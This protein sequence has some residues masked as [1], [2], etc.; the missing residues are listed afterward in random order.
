MTK[1]ESEDTLENLETVRITVIT[2]G[3]L[4]FSS[5]NVSED[6]HEAW[7]GRALVFPQL[8][9]ELGLAHTPP[10]SGHGAL[11]VPPLPQALP[12]PS[13]QGFRNSSEELVKVL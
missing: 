8:G 3:N 10:D 2:R 13:G 7:R 11:W 5:V 1:L 12:E 9:A 6:E 4:S